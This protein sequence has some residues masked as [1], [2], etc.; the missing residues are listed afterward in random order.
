MI[1]SPV[2]TGF[3]RDV[4]DQGA[5]GMMGGGGTHGGRAGDCGSRTMESGAMRRG[6]DFLTHGC[7][8]GQSVLWIF[9]QAFPQKQCPKRT[10]S[11]N[12]LPI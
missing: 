11:Y 12:Q 2:H 1:G 5:E 6:R 9:P 4:E 10:L 7:G 3:D 8:K